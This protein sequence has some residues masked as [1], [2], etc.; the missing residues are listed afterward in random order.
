MLS[1]DQNF[2]SGCD[3]YAILRL[4]SLLR[5]QTLTQ[6]LLSHKNKI[7]YRIFSRDILVA[8]L[9]SLPFYFSSGRGESLGT[10][11]LRRMLR[12]YM[13]RSRFG[14]GT[15]AVNSRGGENRKSP[16]S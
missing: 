15:L 1:T 12:F 13:D 7:V 3:R 8:A 10:R 4:N 2:D 14:Y 16:F 11:L 5:S 6:N 9:A